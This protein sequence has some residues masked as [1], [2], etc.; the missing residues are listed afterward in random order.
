MYF[1]TRD[2]FKSFLVC[3]DPFN[4]KNPFLILTAYQVGRR[5]SKLFILYKQINT[6]YNNLKTLILL[7]FY[8]YKYTHYIIILFNLL[9]YKEKYSSWC[10]PGTCTI[11]TVLLRKLILIIKISGGQFFA[12]PDFI[13]II[14]RYK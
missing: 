8:L 10:V 14:F 9:L 11:D 12:T 1:V 13:F 2:F 6:E 5:A 3:K 4:C 7:Y